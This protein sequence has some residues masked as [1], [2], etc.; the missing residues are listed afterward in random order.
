MQQ[1]PDARPGVGLQGP[2]GA[3]QPS[4]GFVKLARPGQVAGQRDERGR[5]HRLC[6]PTVPVGERDR[7]TASLP[8]DGEGADPRRETQL[9]KA[10]DFQVWPA[11][12]PGQDGALLEVAFSV[13]KPQ[14]PRLQGPQVH[15]RHRAQVAAQRDIFVGLPRYR[16][17]KEPGL[18]R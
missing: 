10:A 1:L 14:G 4:L 6:P 3:L 11:D 15:Q 16:G 18:L 12:A 9:R 5:N 13:W 8:G 17:G 7:L 2:C